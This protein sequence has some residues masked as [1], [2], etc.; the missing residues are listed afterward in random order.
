[1]TAPDYPQGRLFTSGRR[2][3]GRMRRATDATVKVLR[4]LGRLELVDEAVVVALR[5]AAD[6][7]DAAEALRARDEATPF[8]VANALRTLLVATGALYARVGLLEPSPDDDLYAL[9]ST[10]PDGG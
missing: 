3:R 7:V 10:P 8:M 2:A 6:N 9:L 5:C 1:M 4:E